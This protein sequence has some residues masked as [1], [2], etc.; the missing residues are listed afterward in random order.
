MTNAALNMTSP[1]PPS[2]LGA[3]ERLVDFIFSKEPLGLGLYVLVNIKV[4]AVTVMLVTSPYI[5]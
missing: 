4:T 1:A 2:P 5:T 3:Q